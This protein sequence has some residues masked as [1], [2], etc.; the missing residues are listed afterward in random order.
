[1][2]VTLSAKNSGI[3]GFLKGLTMRSAS[4]Q[5]FLNRNV[6][7]AYQNIQ[8]KRWITENVSETGQWTPLSPS[9]AKA[10]K[11]RF[12]SYPG[13]GQKLLIATDK[14]RKSVIGPG[15]GFR[16][17]T[18]PRSLII[19]TAT[20]Y[21]EH[22]DASRT[23]STYSRESISELNGMIKDFVFKNIVRPHNNA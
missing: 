7:R 4:L 19:T 1:M 22:V 17:I 11:T 14:L 23:F 10:K 8:R 13:A 21:A 3:E 12:K 9:Y 6:Y 20:P 2:N 16:K 15:E 5:S 18:T